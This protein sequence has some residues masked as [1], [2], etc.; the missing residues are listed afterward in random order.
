MYFYGITHF[1]ELIDIPR[2]IANTNMKTE[3]QSNNFEIVWNAIIG[4]KRPT[5]SFPFQPNWGAIKI[6]Y[7]HMNINYCRN[8]IDLDGR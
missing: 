4:K 3:R 8:V 6:Y 5:S 2:S 7:K 1:H